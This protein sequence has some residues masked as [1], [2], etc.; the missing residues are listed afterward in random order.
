MQYHHRSA[1]GASQK[2][3]RN[4]TCCFKS[5]V[6]GG[7]KDKSKRHWLNGRCQNHNSGSGWMFCSV[8]QLDLRP[9]VSNEDVDP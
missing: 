6:V 2:V 8:G 7:K 9:S 1:E 4:N 3:S 5:H